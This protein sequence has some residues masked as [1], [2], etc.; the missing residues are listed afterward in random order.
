M[1]SPTLKKKI[2]LHFKRQRAH[3]ET[4]CCTCNSYV[5]EFPR[6][7]LGDTGLLSI[8]PRCKIMGLKSG[9]AYRVQP[10]HGCDAHDN[11]EYLARIECLARTA[12]K[13]GA[14]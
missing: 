12:V 5:A 4:I 6:T 9:R 3:S 8:E 13:A 7:G 11:S 1:G 2:E 10:Y 14:L